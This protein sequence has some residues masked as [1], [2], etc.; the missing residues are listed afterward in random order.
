M[1]VARRMARGRAARGQPRVHRREQEHGADEHDRLARRPR[2]RATRR[3]M[4]CS[5][6]RTP[7]GRRWRTSIRAAGRRSSGSIPARR[8]ARARR[9][10]TPGCSPGGAPTMSSSPAFSSASAVVAP[11]SASTPATPATNPPSLARVCSST[12]A[13]HSATV[14]PDDARDLRDDVAF[15]PARVDEPR[16]H[17]ERDDEQRR[18]R[19]RRVVSQRGRDAHDVDARPDGPRPAWHAATP[20]DED[21][22]RARLVTVRSAEATVAR[23]DRSAAMAA[24][25]APRQ[26]SEPPRERREAHRP[27]GERRE[28][29]RLPP[30]TPTQW[31]VR[32]RARARA[33]DGFVRRVPCASP[34]TAAEPMSH[35]GQPRVRSRACRG[36]GDVTADRRACRAHPRFHRL[37]RVRRSGRGGVRR[38]RPLSH[39]FTH[40]SHR[41]RGTRCGQRLRIQ[42][43]ERGRDATCASAPHRQA[44]HPAITGVG[45][46]DEHDRYEREPR[47]SWRAQ[48]RRTRPRSPRRA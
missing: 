47:R 4:S 13:S 21:A 29:A 1:S 25:P 31:P 10:T 27:T 39:R 9:T 6:P 16:R 20:P 7:R 37:R 36:G 24:K 11:T 46:C 45:P 34:A 8:P 32:L 19:E 26:G 15:E 3:A 23:P 33:Q 43:H 44:A 48:P 28:A 14:R 18:D 17:A 40:L 41:R 35:S 12:S 22:T 5:R 2:D 38:S 30:T 42:S